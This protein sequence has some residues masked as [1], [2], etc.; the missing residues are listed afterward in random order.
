LT[1]F[2]PL[3]FS[4]FYS[5]NQHVKWTKVL[6]IVVTND[7]RSAYIFWNRQLSNRYKVL[8]LNPT[9]A[10]WKLL[11]KLRNR[12]GFDFWQEPR[13]AGGNLDIMVSPE[14]FPSFLAFLYVTRVSYTVLNQ[15]VQ[16]WV[17]PRF[18]I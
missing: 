11:Q 10:Q 9:E 5:K 2:L 17:Y 15:N 4:T 12:P 1:L 8:R 13:R 7:K 18:I 16:T 3:N 6:P 14:K